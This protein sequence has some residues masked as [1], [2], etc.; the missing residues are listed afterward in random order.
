MSDYKS[1]R[2]AFGLSRE[3]LSNLAKLAGV[4]VSPM[5]IKKLEDEGEKVIGSRSLGPNVVGYLNYVLGLG[6]YEGTDWSSVEKGAPVI[7]A[8]QKGVFSFVSIDDDGNIT[9]FSDKFRNFHADDVR[10]VA[11][12]AL[13]S[14]SDAALFETRTRGDGG[15][16]ARIVMTYISDHSDAPHAVGSL[17]Y[18]LGLDSG[19]VSRTVAGLVKAGK[20]AKVGRGVVT[21]PGAVEAPAAPTA[22]PE[23]EAPAADVPD[24]ENSGIDF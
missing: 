3:K 4:K 15:Q 21:L 22:A 13:P 8:G 23:V 7:V 19:V 17:A 16:Y 1:A 12:T 24:A 11:P 10:L 9:M 20:L 14:V 5:T 2:E 6:D 18:A